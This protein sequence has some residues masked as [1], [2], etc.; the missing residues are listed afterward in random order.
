[1]ARIGWVDEA[2]ATGPIADVYARWMAANPGRTE[3][4][5][6][7][8]CLSLRP[9]VFELMDAASDEIHFNAGHLDC[10]TKEILATYISALNQTNY[11]TGSHAAF[12]AKHDPTPE[13]PRALRD[14]DLDAAGLTPAERGLL[15]FAAILTRHAAKTT[16]ADVARLR[17]LGWTDPQI[18]EAV[19]VTAM[20]A[21]FNRVAD[22]FG[23]DDPTG[24]A[25]FRS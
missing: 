6:I 20:F 16:D 10:R 12:L 13:L 14:L 24:F 21:F 15:D 25:A 4:P 8:K 9:A 2:A 7:L 23:L 3:I 17:D 22:A 11:C 19:Y 5:A 18:A 1:M